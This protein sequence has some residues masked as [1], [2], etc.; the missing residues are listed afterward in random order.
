MWPSICAVILTHR[1]CNGTA[2]ERALFTLVTELIAVCYYHIISTVIVSSLS[3]IHY[4]SWNLIFRKKCV[5]THGKVWIVPPFFFKLESY[6]LPFFYVQ[7]LYIMYIYTYIYKIKFKT[8]SVL[9]AMSPG[10]ITFFYNNSAAAKTLHYLK[11]ENVHH[12]KSAMAECN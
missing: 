6:F 3:L 8:S 5:C 1:K 12:I 11:E 9:Y 7:I 4:W 10:G 2:V